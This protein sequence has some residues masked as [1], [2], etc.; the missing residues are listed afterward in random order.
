[1]HIET[2]PMDA[3]D[4]PASSLPS[5]RPATPDLGVSPPGQRTAKFGVVE[6]PLFGGD[7]G[8]A[9]TPLELLRLDRKRVLALTPRRTQTRIAVGLGLTGSTFSNALAGRERFAATAAAVLRQWVN[10]AEAKPASPPTIE[11]FLRRPDDA[12]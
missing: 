8:A 4:G 11:E 2:I 3:G 1:M 12:A 7:F 5:S 10:A 6:V 9:P